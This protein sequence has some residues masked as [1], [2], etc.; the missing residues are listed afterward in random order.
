[1]TKLTR[2]EATALLLDALKTLHLPIP[3][4]GGWTQI[5]ADCA[6]LSKQRISNMATDGRK[7]VSLK[8]KSV[9]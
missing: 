5:L 9:S 7:S 1:V 4:R 6:C 2:E 8:R 3:Y